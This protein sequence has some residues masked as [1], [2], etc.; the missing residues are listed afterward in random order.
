MVD[1]RKYAEEKAAQQKAAFDKAKHD[2]DKQRQDDI[3][4]RLAILER[5]YVVARPVLERAKAELAGAKLDL[6][7]SDNA[8]AYDKPAPELQVRAKS[9]RGTTPGTLHIR[10]AANNVAFLFKKPSDTHGGHQVLFCRGDEFNAEAVETAVK[11][12]VDK[13]FPG[14]QH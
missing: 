14:P 8:S 11:Y 7:W 5:V 13:L 9:E 6:S 3:D 1:F 10:P 12:L 2:R 4:A